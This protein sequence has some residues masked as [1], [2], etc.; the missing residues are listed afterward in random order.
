MNKKNKKKKKNLLEQQVKL[1]MDFRGE[2]CREVLGFSGL[3][4]FH[5]L[6]QENKIC[7]RSS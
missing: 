7:H 6:H 4:S 1:S 3:L 2:L 5:S